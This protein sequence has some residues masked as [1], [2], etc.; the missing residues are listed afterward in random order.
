MES[1]ALALVLCSGL[2]ITVMSGSARAD[3]SDDAL[4]IADPGNDPYN[5]H[6]KGIS[7]DGKVVV[8]SADFT[9]GT[10]A[11]SWDTFRNVTPL[12]VPTGATDGE[13]T[14]T[15]TDGSVIVGSAVVGNLRQAIRWTSAGTDLLDTI[16]GS[17]N[18]YANGVSGDGSIIVGYVDYNASTYYRQAFRWSGGTMVGLDGLLSGASSVA[19]G[20]SRDGSVIVGTANDGDYDRA[21]RWT[22]DGSQIGQL[23]L[24]TGGTT[25]SALAVNDDGSVVVGFANTSNVTHAFRWTS[26][27]GTKDIDTLESTISL[28]NAV[29]GDGSVV[30]GQVYSGQSFRAFRWTEA[31]GMMTVE[32]W[33]RSKDIAFS[34]DFTNSA[35]GIS[36]DGNIIVGGTSSGG[37]FVARVTT[38]NTGDGD[39]PGPT[40]GIIDVQQYNTTLVAK[41][42]TQVGLGYANTVLQGAHGEPMR[43]LLGLGQRSVAFTSDIGYDDS[44][45]SN[46][47]VGIGDVTF[48]YGLAEGVTARF[49]GGGLYT[50][51]DIE[52]GGDFHQAAF[53]MSPE[54]TIALGSSNVY[55]TI[56]GYYSTGRMNIHRGYMNGAAMDFSH[57]ET[58]VDTY[59]AKIRFDWLNAA[60]IAGTKLTPYASLTYA[61]SHM[62][63][64]TEEG[65]SFPSAFDSVNDHSTVARIGVDF[66]HD[67]T[68]T[69]R[70]TARA[71][72]DYRFEKTT[73][74]TSG[75]IVGLSAFEFDGEDVKQLWLRGAI[76]TEF[77][78]AGGTAS[79]GI[80]V[81]TEGDDPNVW[82]R[83]G[84]NVKF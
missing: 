26:A 28:A 37:M 66:I 32:D 82:L 57:G 74:G 64:Y 11:I 49:A 33:L 43:D 84:W 52:T 60:T 20:I 65:G 34:Y 15:N 56:G 25:S 6:T 55:A 54:A 77:D 73:A 4:T 71:E 12:N 42:S 76:G 75:Q 62:D 9:Q 59:G 30:V 31:T 53:Y 72:A 80:N 14:A 17:S 8:G 23:P 51:Q 39:T 7:G 46:G 2:A 79:L 10:Q 35:T 44:R 18:S 69:V 48:G 5:F 40:S 58:D 63:G 1:S 27:G 19:N 78:V 68:E 21:V 61:H 24:L 36:A 81:T 41:P 47:G 67:V 3:S 22:D 13:A 70:L 29:S 83:S 16:A 38:P 45:V 50:K